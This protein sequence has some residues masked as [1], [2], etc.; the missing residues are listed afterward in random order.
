MLSL[1]SSRG[2]RQKPTKQSSNRSK[3]AALPSK[4]TPQISKSDITAPH[5]PTRCDYPIPPRSRSLTHRNRSTKNDNNGVRAG[6]VACVQIE[7]EEKAR[8]S[9]ICKE[10]QDQ[11][12]A[13]GTSVPSRYDSVAR[14]SRSSSLTGKQGAHQIAVSTS[15]L[16]IDTNAQALPSAAL[17]T[18][19]AN[20]GEQSAAASVHAAEFPDVTDDERALLEK[21]RQRES[22]RKAALFELVD[23]ERSFTK[24]LRMV[25]ELFLLP[26]QHLGNRKI[27]EVI[28]GDMVKI[29]EMNGMMYRDMVERLGPLASLVDPER[30]SRALRK[31]KTP[32]RLSN[33][34][35][36]ASA[37]RSVLQSSTLRSPTTPVSV[38]AA[39]SSTMSRRLSNPGDRQGAARR[40]SMHSYID[41]GSI[42]ES[43]A[44]SRSDSR[45]DDGASVVSNG[46]DNFSI[47]TTGSGGSGNENGVGLRYVS[48]AGSISAGAMRHGSTRSLNAASEFDENDASKWTDD[49]VLEYFRNV[50]IGDVV[51]NYLKDF[52]EHYARYSA[53]HDKAVEYLKLVRESSSRLNLRSDATRDAHQRLLQTLEKAEKDTRVRRLRLESFLL[54][55]VQRVMRYPLLLEALLKYT[56]EEHPDHEDVAL[57]LSI[58]RSAATEVDRKSEELMNRQ[59]LAELQSTFDWSHLLGGVQLKL[60][61]FTKLVGQRKFVRKGPLRKASSGRHLYAILFNDFMMITMSER[62]GG[63]WCYEAYRLPIQTYDLLAREPVK[64]MFELVNLKDSE[65][66]QL[67][68]DTPAEAADWVKDIMKTAD[69]CYGVMSDAIRSGIQVSKVKSMHSP[70]ARQRILMGGK[71]S[72]LSK[73]H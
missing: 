67:R 55:P 47:A 4:P 15:P 17:E 69:Y 20:T 45:H 56:P 66:L 11:P 73:R 33:S 53:N 40:S 50:C 16:S 63:V 35:H 48:A 27:V 39:A 34:S 23:T 24:D 68:A 54:A 9:A 64:D 14:P 70:E 8:L 30:A 60:D 43:T 6:A 58:A 62:R 36:G 5:L 13:A 2:Y 19:T 25:V 41:N 12:P 71:P 7:E 28:F 59:R 1:F 29:T 26:I 72:V 46:A 65:V 42:A 18:P 44:L 49:Q 57:A 3:P 31:K 37:A 52:S 32:L 51:S 22:K 10:Y 21:D 61:T 38:S